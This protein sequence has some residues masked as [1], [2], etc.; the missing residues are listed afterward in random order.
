MEIK[1]RIGMAKDAFQLRKIFKDR[2]MSINTKLRVLDC[3]LKSIL[4]YGSECWAISTQMEGRVVPQVNVQN[5]L[6]RPCYKL[7]G[8][9]K[10]GKRKKLNEIH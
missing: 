6:D 8:N 7:R 10:G 4:T 2:K 1:K 3:F 9:N 5:I